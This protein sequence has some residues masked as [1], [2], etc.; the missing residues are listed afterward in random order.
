MRWQVLKGYA[1]AI[2]LKAE[3]RVAPLDPKVGIVLRYQDQDN[4]HAACA[5]LA[6]GVDVNVVIDLMIG[7]GPR[8][9]SR[10]VA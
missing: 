3:Y 4:A 9:R 2:S 5:M 1:H 10:R 8:E 6:A 7:T